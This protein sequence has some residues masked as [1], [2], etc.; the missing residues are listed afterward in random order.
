VIIYDGINNIKTQTI[1]VPEFIN[2][3][4]VRLKFIGT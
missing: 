1:N 2:I 4:F 3:K